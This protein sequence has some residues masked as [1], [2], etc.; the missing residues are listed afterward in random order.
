M[1]AWVILFGSIAV[2]LVPLLKSALRKPDFFAPAFIFAIGF[3]ASYGFKA[4]LIEI[5]PDL[6]LTYPDIHSKYPNDVSTMGLAVFLSWI[7]LLSFYVGYY[8]KSGWRIFPR[9]TV[10]PKTARRLGVLVMVPIFLG[11]CSIG[12]LTYIVL[13][14]T[15]L[16]VELTAEVF[17]NVLTASWEEYPL[18]FHF[19]VYIGFFG[20]V[21]THAFI[22][23][24]LKSRENV[25]LLTGALVAAGMVLLLLGSRAL[26]LSFIVSIAI[27][28]H[29]FVKRIRFSTQVAMLSCIVFLGG[30]LGIVQKLDNPIGQQAVGL[31]FPENIVFRLSSSYEQFDSLLYTIQG[32]SFETLEWGRTFAEDVFVTYFPRALWPDKPT[33]YGF[34]RAQ[35]VVFGDYWSISH[36]TTYPIGTL[37]ELYLNFG[38]PGIV[39]GMFLLGFVLKQL[40]LRARDQASLYPAIFCA[41][42]ASFLAPHR[43]YGTIFLTVLIY[44]FMSFGLSLLSSSGRSIVGIRRMAFVATDGART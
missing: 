38:Y 36:G 21:A 40:Q 34:I 19:P 4:F 23:G 31:E 28:R 18:F 24:S 35:N 25:F 16:S 27:Y 26:L 8:S 7:G 33:E 41:I 10:S 17:R 13:E 12:A 20:L 14:A 30:F 43:T 39:L 44:C 2:M 22:Y 11:I 42:V 3:T 37:G 32:T 29:Y 1:N 15:T 6:Y 5:D 9:W